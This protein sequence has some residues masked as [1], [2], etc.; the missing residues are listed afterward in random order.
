MPSESVPG[1]VPSEDTVL[2]LAHAIRTSLM[3][4]GITP[5]RHSI[6]FS[7]WGNIMG[8]IMYFQR[9]GNSRVLQGLITGVMEGL[10]PEVPGEKGT[11]LEAEQQLIEY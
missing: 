10:M 5:H 11:V 9:C 8:S 2:F 7:L 4:C 1:H 6:S 3:I